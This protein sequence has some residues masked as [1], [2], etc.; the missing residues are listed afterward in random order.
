MVRERIAAG[1]IAHLSVF[2]L[3]PIP[4]L[5][6]LGRLMRTLYDQIKAF[7]G[8]GA[9][10]HVFPAVPASVAVEIGR[11]RMPKADLPLLVYDQVPGAPFMPRIS[12]E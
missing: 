10:I 9:I 5:V 8:Q 2:A 7:H 1:E 3:G 11:V 12:I 6:Q 4:L